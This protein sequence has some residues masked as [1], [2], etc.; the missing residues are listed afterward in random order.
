MQLT[1][2]ELMNKIVEIE[3]NNFP[4]MSLDGENVYQISEEGIR[5]IPVSE[6]YSSF[7]CECYKDGFKPGQAVLVD[8]FDPCICAKCKKEIKVI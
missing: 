2:E 4:P 1:P 8:T 3:F 7:Y 5:E 6:F